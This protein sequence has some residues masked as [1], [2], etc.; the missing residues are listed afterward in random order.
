MSYQQIYDL[1]LEGK[2]FEDI[3]N[4]TGISIPELHNIIPLV[5]EQINKE[6][7]EKAP[8]AA[9]INYA[10]LEVLIQAIMTKVSEANARDLV[11]LSNALS[12]LIEEQDRLKNEIKTQKTIIPMAEDKKETTTKITPN[13]EKKRTYLERHRDKMGS[14]TPGERGLLESLEEH[15]PD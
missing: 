9:A 4:K 3:A 15:D 13:E 8:N 2:S 10:R 5:Y 6:F 1:V 12:R 7:A 14:L 11:S